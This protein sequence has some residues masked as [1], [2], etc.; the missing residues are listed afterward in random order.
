MR[1]SSSGARKARRT[2]DKLLDSPRRIRSTLH[3][4]H[5]LLKIAGG[6]VVCFSHLIALAGCSGRSRGAQASVV[7]NS[8]PADVLCGQR[9]DGLTHIPPRFN[10]FMPPERGASYT[11][12]QYGCAVIRLTDAKS[13]FKLAIHH[14]Y[15]TISAVNQD[16][17]RVM[18]LTEWGQGTIVDM[19]GNTVV[20]PRDFPGMNAGNVPWASNSSDTFYYTNGNTLY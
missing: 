15:S 20:A 3:S 12:P 8:M 13:Q 1:S 11:D 9:D 10:D 5:R 17:A 2:G 14:Q 6:I 7:P 18:L 4:D 19:N 16:D